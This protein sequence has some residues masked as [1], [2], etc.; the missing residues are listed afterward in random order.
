MCSLLDL[1]VQVDLLVV[2]VS[3]WDRAVRPLL[4]GAGFGRHFDETC[5]PHKS[6]F[7]WLN[8]YHRPSII[9]QKSSLL[10]MFSSKVAKRKV[11]GSS[12]GDR[13]AKRS[14]SLRSTTPSSTTN[15]KAQKSSATEKQLVRVH[16]A[17]D[18]PHNDSACRIGEHWH[19]AA[20]CGSTGVLLPYIWHFSNGTASIVSYKGRCKNPSCN[21]DCAAVRETIRRS[22]YRLCK[23]ADCEDCRGVR[24]VLV[25][26]AKSSSSGVWA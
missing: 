18:C 16:Y 1:V 10:T 17:K 25:R 7:D 22:Q 14:S 21:N 8:P 4:I 2:T 13:V 9:S 15:S 11:I 23:N 20:R 19:L 12:K 5:R 6:I 26:K 24:D 3:D